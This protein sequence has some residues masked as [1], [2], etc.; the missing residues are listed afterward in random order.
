MAEKWQE[1]AKEN[2]KLAQ[3]LLGWELTVRNNLHRAREAA[4]LEQWQL[5]ARLGWP[6]KKVQKIESVSGGDLKFSELRQYLLATG[7]YIEFHLRGQKSLG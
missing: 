5:A 7:H 4:G 3:A 1:I 6:L 2:P